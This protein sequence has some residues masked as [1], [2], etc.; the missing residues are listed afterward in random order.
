MTN[1]LTFLADYS[2]QNLNTFG[3]AAHASQFLRIQQLAQLQAIFADGQL[4]TLPRLILGGG[5]NLVLSDHVD[6]LVLQ[7]C[8]KGR[9][10]LSEDDNYVYVQAAAGENWHEFVLW[11]LEQGLGGLENLSL[12]PGTVGA[13]PIQNIGA[14]GIEIQEVFSSLSAFD[15]VTGQLVEIDRAACRF[16]YRDS[17][18]KQEYKDRMVILS[19]RFALPKRWQARLGYADVSQYLSQH[20]IANP[21]ARDISEAVIAIRQAKLPDPAS[22][23]NAG[24][25]FKNPIVSASLR[26]SLLAVYP[27]LVS[28]QQDSGDYK[29]AAGWLIDQC[30][31]KGRQLGKAGV[32]EKQALVLVNHGGASGAEVRALAQAIQADVMG[33]FGVL[34][35][36]E[37][38]F[39]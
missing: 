30:G 21:G 31:W 14:Y 13:A 3:I 2:L 29:L 15:F 34:L 11:T 22:I 1:L 33:K 10:I 9:E 16:A 25:F 7:M 24:S 23:G 32:Y 35:E 27:G 8:M 37:P 4:K 17:I 19:V 28:Y 36:V 6:A 5:S 26:D 12:I 20:R 39:F 18:F 38:V